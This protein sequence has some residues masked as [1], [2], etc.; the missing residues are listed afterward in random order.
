MHRLELPK[1]HPRTFQNVKVE[2]K[3]TQRK[4]TQRKETAAENV[5]MEMQKN[6]ITAVSQGSFLARHASLVTASRLF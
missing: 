2:E 1:V 4:D 5:R 3:H 6:V